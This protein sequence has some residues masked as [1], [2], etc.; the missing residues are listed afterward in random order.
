MHPM[1][2]SLSKITDSD[3]DEKI[4]K[5]YK[6]LAVSP[7]INITRQ[8]EMALDDYL[9]EQRNRANKKLDDQFKKAGKKMKDIIDIQ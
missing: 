9:N 8:A 3:L 4:T 2:G 1:I 5:L 6:V 7:N